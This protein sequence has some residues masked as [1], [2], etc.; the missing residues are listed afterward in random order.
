MLQKRYIQLQ[1]LLNQANRLKTLMTDETECKINQEAYDRRVIWDPFARKLV[2]FNG[3]DG[4]ESFLGKKSRFQKVQSL[5]HLQK[6]GS[7]CR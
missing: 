5:P 1:Q 7:H 3:N 4:D 6:E 2:D